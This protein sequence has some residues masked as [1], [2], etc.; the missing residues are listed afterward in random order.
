MAQNMTKKSAKQSSITNFM[1]GKYS[2]LEDDEVEEIDSEEDEN[3]E[4][5]DNSQTTLTRS[6]AILSEI[7]SMRKEVKKNFKDLNKT[8]REIKRSLEF[9]HAE[10][11]DL[12]SSNINLVGETENLS[13]R[14]DSLEA[15]IKIQEEKQNNEERRS[16]EYNIRI[17]GIKEEK[18]ED[19]K[20]KVLNTLTAIG[21]LD[22][23]DKE[24]LYEHIEVAHRIRYMYTENRPSD[25]ADQNRH[26]IAIEEKKPQQI[27][28]KF[29]K[30]ETRN[31]IIKDTKNAK[32]D[33]GNKFIFEDLTKSD[34][35]RKQ[36]AAPLMTAAFE[37]GQ[38]CRFFRG[39][40]YIE[41]QN[42]SIPD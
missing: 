29:F 37:A 5:S 24:S 41:G 9:A 8:V 11:A 26:S 10:I 39:K 32:N 25:S 36:R 15:K 30:K 1:H 4:M 12:K 18:G 2:A 19:C 23:I 35:K 22:G 16:R 42:V 7:R 17:I 13:K 6:G 3:D 40:L 31:K 14:C 38:K 21:V 28:V 33:Q 27:I 34:F 20:A